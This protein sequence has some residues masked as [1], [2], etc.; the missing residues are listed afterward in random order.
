METWLQN[1]KCGREGVETG[2]TVADALSEISEIAS[3]STEDTAAIKDI[4]NWLNDFA[5]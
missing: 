5:E 1:R 2:R 3:E 4:S